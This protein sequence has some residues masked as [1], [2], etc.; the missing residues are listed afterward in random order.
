MTVTDRII[1][2]NNDWD[3]QDNGLYPS[4]E[5]EPDPSDRQIIA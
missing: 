2:E 5:N 1:H 3:L 4:Q